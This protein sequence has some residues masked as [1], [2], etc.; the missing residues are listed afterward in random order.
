[1][2][3]DTDDEFAEL[4]L[5]HIERMDVLNHQHAQAMELKEREEE[6]L[7]AR[8]R[9][10]RSEV[11]WNASKEVATFLIVAVAVVLI[12]GGIGYWIFT[13]T[14]PTEGEMNHDQVEQVREEAC[15]DRGGGWIGENQAVGD[16]GICVMPGRQS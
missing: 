1:M 5:T 6:G 8:A 2:T 11:R 12:L 9:L 15:Y 10:K 4:P 13:A 14:R 16:N 7:T 3:K